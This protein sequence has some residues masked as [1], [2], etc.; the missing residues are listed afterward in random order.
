MMAWSGSWWPVLIVMPVVMVAM[1][2]FMV[3]MMRGTFGFG[4]HRHSDRSALDQPPPPFVTPPA[5]D[6]MVILRERLVEG[7]IDLAEYEAR[8][9]AL[10]RSDPDQKMPWWNTDPSGETPGSTDRGTRR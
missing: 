7:D 6:P 4:P 3:S 2:A 10:L 8:L 9:E 1:M 5:R